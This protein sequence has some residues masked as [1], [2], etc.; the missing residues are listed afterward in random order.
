[1][2]LFHTDEEF[3]V[4][5]VPHSGVPFLVGSAAEFVEPA[6]DYLYEVAVVRGRT[7][8]I[9]TWKTYGKHLY[10]Y[11]SFLEENGLEWD[12]IKRSH[13]VAWRR[14]MLDRANQVTTINHRLRSVARFYDWASSKGMI[15]KVPY[16]RE[17][18]KVR[19]SR[20]RYGENDASGGHSQANELTLRAPQKLPKFL[21]WEDSTRFVG[22]LRP[23]RNKIIACLM[24][25]AGLRLEEAARLDLR[26]LPNPRKHSPGKPLRMY[27]DPDRTPTKGNVERVVYLPYDL[28]RQLTQYVLFE[29]GALLKRYRKRR[30]RAQEATAIFLNKDGETVSLTAIEN[31]FQRASQESGIKATPHVLRHTYATYEFLR[32]TEKQGRD[33]A[34]QWVRD[35]LGHRSIETTAIYLHTS[36]LVTYE[37]SDEYHAEICAMLRDGTDAGSTR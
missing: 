28:S 6:N 7:A 27:L 15:A 29:R 26:V 13:V 18:V 34:L 35:R 8:S 1:M 25:L 21:L 4:H 16:D 11:F 37:E 14:S 23:H 19:R 3:L 17:T 30:G 20:S 9:H 24:L 31:E 32:L 22:H 2:R 36:D 12:K 33:G 10:E 5:G